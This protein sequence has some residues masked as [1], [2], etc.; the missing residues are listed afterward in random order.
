MHYGNVACTRGGILS[1]LSLSC[2]SMVTNADQ[3]KWRQISAV[4]VF[5]GF[6]MLRDPGADR[7]AEGEHGSGRESLAEGGG[8]G[9]LGG[10]G[11]GGEGEFF[12]CPF[13]P[14][15]PVRPR[16]S[17]GS[18]RFYGGG[19]CVGLSKSV[20]NLK[21]CGLRE[22]A[23]TSEYVSEKTLVVWYKNWKLWDRMLEKKRAR[24]LWVGSRLYGNVLLCS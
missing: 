7:A 1:R 24:F 5:T 3:R 15:F 4:S 22:W 8:T 23:I 16:S 11:R 14:Q 12:L 9:R 13:P 10:E 21:T 18:L 2:T 20:S 17:F 6:I 19:W